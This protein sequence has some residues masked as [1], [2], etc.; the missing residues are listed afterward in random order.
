MKVSSV[1]IGPDCSVESA[2]QIYLLTALFLL[3]VSNNCVGCLMF[4]IQWWFQ[5][6]LFPLWCY[7]LLDCETGGLLQKNINRHSISY[8]EYYVQYISESINSE[9]TILEKYLSKVN[10]TQINKCGTVD[11]PKASLSICRLRFCSRCNFNLV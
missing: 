8:L 5:S 11:K 2:T 9:K 6:L 10:Y 3:I 7:F 4:C 1:G